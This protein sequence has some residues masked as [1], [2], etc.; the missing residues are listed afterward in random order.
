MFIEPCAGCPP[1]VPHLIPSA[2]VGAHQA[3]LLAPYQ[4]PYQVFLGIKWGTH[5]PKIPMATHFTDKK[6][7]AES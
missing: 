1:G 5:F 2:A 7:E 6:A 4:L 3:I